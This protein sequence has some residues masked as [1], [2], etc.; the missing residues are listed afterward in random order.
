MTAKGEL[1]GYA[2]VSTTGQKLNAQIAQLKEFG[3]TDNHIFTDKLSGLTAQRPSLNEC[4]KFVRRGDTLVITK[5]D[6]LARST[7]HLHQIVSDLNDKGV[8][9]KVLDQSIDT[10]TNE[11][12]LLFTMLAAIAE[13][14]TS[15]RRDRQISGI[16]N[17]KQRG[18]KFG[19]KAKL[20]PEQIEV[21]Y[22][23]RADG[24][25]IK[26]LMSE[27][28]I[29]K[30]SVYRL[31]NEYEDASKP[32]TSYIEF[33]DNKLLACDDSDLLDITNPDS[34]QCQMLNESK[35]RPRCRVKN[36]TQL[37]KIKVGERG[38]VCHACPKH[39][40]E[41]KFGELIQP[42]GSSHTEFGG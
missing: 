26:D 28:G 23:K 34:K 30:A 41:A 9:F 13:F 4:L 19:A 37:V 31:L 10:T 25:L 22:Q 15:L 38:M 36:D 20:T 1:I 32:T 3:C 6:R 24:T 21:M 2:R 17:A 7:L 35:N 18:V 42:H 14:E 8:G 11:G 40:K 5:M 12:R 16:E 27:Y 39:I 29:S 33:N